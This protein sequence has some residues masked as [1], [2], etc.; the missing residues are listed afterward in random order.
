M[1][2]AMGMPSDTLAQKRG[3]KKVA[4][5]VAVVQEPTEEEVNFEN[6]LPATA[7]VTFI[8]SMIVPRNSFAKSINI[9]K[10]AGSV[11]MLVRDDVSTYMYTNEIASN[12]IISLCDSTGNNRLYRM[13][14]LGSK[15]DKPEPIV[16]PG[17]FTD[18][19]CPFLLSDG[20]TLYFSARGGEDNVGKH[21]IFF[22]I[23]DTDEGK[24]IT[25]Q[26]VGLP[27][28]STDDDFY[29]VIDE[30]NSIGYLVTARRQDAENVCVYT[31]IPT[32]SRETYSLDDDDDDT[33]LKALAELQSIEATQTNVTELADAR[34]RLAALRGKSTVANN[35]FS[36][37]ITAKRV[38]HKLSDFKS[39][40]NRD[41]F[42]DYQRR[43]EALKQQEERLASL[44][45]DFHNGQKHIAGEILSLE[46][47]I[48]NERIA[49]RNLAGT[50]RQQE[51]Q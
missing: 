6:L 19:I 36:F 22:T 7:K 16:I 2:I 10:S 43:T 17:D 20:V 42:L 28:N 50:I 44:R 41:R 25:P 34:Q 29:Y 14:K 47:T 45:N 37:A 8:D 38:Y 5:P 23:Y 35:G 4:K 21:D 12:R 49:L 24:F 27:F 11:E 30:E 48:E 18:L 33:R 31:F 39:A 51:V 3:K 46:K 32:E 13:S 40:E 1:L 15:W 9:A 26:S